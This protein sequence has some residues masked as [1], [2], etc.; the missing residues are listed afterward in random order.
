MLGTLAEGPCGLQPRGTAFYVSLET[1][2]W[3]ESNKEPRRDPAPLASHWEEEEVCRGPQ[4]ELSPQVT[5]ASL[6]PLFSSFSKTWASLCSE[7]A[8]ARSKLPSLSRGRPEARAGSPALCGDSTHLCTTSTGLLRAFPTKV[9]SVG[10][11]RRLFQAQSKTEGGG[12][13]DS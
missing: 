1:N 7:R 2:L 8:E 13:R 9:P 12:K 10:P 6:D 11:R 4:R 5:Q 3:G